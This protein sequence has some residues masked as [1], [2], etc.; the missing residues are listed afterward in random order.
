[1]FVF[2]LFP[3]LYKIVNFKFHLINLSR[4]AWVV[5]PLGFA[6][7]VSMKIMIVSSEI[8]LI[9][10]MRGQ[11]QDESAPVSLNLFFIVS[12]VMKRFFTL[13]TK[14]KDNSHL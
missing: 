8:N 1:M 12:L 10:A 9:Y 14:E 11:M 4:G 13:N 7:F 6:L 3:C 2:Q 5:L